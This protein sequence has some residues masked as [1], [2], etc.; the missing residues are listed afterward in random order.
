MSRRK[1]NRE[2]KQSKRREKCSTYDTPERTFKRKELKA[3]TRKQGTYINAIENHIITVATGYPGTG[4][5][6]IPAVIA[7]NSLQDPSSPIKKIVICRPNAGITASIGLLPG[8]INDK[9]K[10]W[11]AP[12]LDVMYQTLGRTFVEY[13]IAQGVIELLPLEYAR[14]KSYDNTFMILDEA[15]NVEKEALKCILTR[16]GRDTK[17]IIDG[18]IG[19]CDIGSATGLG[20]LINL[21]DNYHTPMAY[22]DFEVDDIVRSD[23]CKY[24]IELFIEAKF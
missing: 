3:L 10:A 23:V 15:Q 4:K 16:I 11:C 17:L 13:L 7:C 22:V 19:Q 21:I 18:D 12:I 24:M 20:Q 8:D 5:S 6:Y 14:G 1:Q 9:M 2:N